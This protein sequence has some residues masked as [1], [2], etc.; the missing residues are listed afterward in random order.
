MG[1][2]LVE[3]LRQYSAVLGQIRH[4]SGDRSFDDRVVE[5]GAS[6]E[7]LRR[8]LLDM[9][10][11]FSVPTDDPS[12]RLRVMNEFLRNVRT[13]LVRLTQLNEPLQQISIDEGA[14]DIDDDE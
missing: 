1:T 2:T 8:R 3:C 14:D 10:D 6:T 4:E 5:M 11:L 7:L 13:T 9:R 12:E